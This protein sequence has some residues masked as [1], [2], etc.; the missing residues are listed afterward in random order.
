MQIQMI[1]KTP[2]EAKKINAKYL[3]GVWTSSRSN[4]LNVDMLSDREATIAVIILVEY[5][6]PVVS[7]GKQLGTNSLRITAETGFSIA[8]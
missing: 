7:C 4:E 1:P 2:V 5:D 6:G 3:A 8:V